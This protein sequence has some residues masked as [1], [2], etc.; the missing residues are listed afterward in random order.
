MK[1]LKNT[2]LLCVIGIFIFFLSC[3]NKFIKFQED[4]PFKILN[5]YM[6]KIIPGQQDGK[7]TIEI[8]FEIE[9]L[10]EEITL[11]SLYYKKK[12]ALKINTR[13]IQRTAFLDSSNQMENKELNANKVLLFYSKGKR[14]YYCILSEIIIKGDLYLP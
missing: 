3:S 6:Q 10:S 13:G 9:G 14:K 1:G 2:L 7:P 11:D 4:P 8:G 12:V 5:V